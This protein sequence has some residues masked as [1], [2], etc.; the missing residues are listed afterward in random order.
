M[1]KSLVYLLFAAN[2]V[3]IFLFWWPGNGPLFESADSRLIMIALGRLGGLFAAFFV[4]CQLVLIG[5]VKWVEALFGLDRLSRAHHWNG[6]LILFFILTHPALLIAG[7]A[8]SQGIGLISQFLDFYRNYEHVALAVF[9]L[10]VFL[11]VIGVSLAIVRLRLRYETWYFT[12]LLVYVA[13]LLSFFHQLEVGTDFEN[14]PAFVVYWYALYIFAVGNFALFRFLRP[15]YYFWK[16]RFRIDRVVRETDEAASIYMT[17]QGLETFQAEPGQFM[18]LRF[19]CRGFWWQAHPFSISQKPDGK[20]LR[21]TIKN[22]GDFT[23]KIPQLAAG[24]K[25][26]IDGPHGVFTEQAARQ[27]KILLIAGGIGITPLRSLAEQMIEH[28]R[29]VAMLYGNR[30]SGEIAL[31]KELDALSGLRVQYIISDDSSWFGPKGRIDKEAI[32]TLVPDFKEREVYLCGPVPMMKSVRAALKRLGLAE[33]M[34]HW[35][36]FSLA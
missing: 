17:G 24:T 2:L 16:Y 1:K 18:I 28:G 8:G 7:Y 35:E 27:K 14:N 34:I 21:V 5:R 26:L 10:L 20:F 30:T 12:H 15:L 23:S 31:K 33:S 6:F 9:A 29:D 13:I 22:V 19:L 4:L 32:Q 25:V 36:K 11:L 3:V